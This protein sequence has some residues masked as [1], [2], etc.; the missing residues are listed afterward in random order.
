MISPDRVRAMLETPAGRI[1]LAGIFAP[2]QA[3]AYA[4]EEALCRYGALCGLSPEVTH[5]VIG[6][7]V[8]YYRSV[9]APFD[10]D[11]YRQALAERALGLTLIEDAIRVIRD[12]TTTGA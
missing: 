1:S 9:G 5:D 2:A 8:A 11:I 6:L 3:A 12:T 7:I 10:Y 4:R